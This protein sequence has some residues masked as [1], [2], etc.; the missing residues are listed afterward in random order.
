[1]ETAQL[2]VCWQRFREEMLRFMD[3]YDLIVSPVC[4][5]AAVPHGQTFAGDC[6]PGFSYTMTHNL[7]GWPV[8]VIRA[9]TTFGGLPIGVQI[10]ARPREEAA[11]LAAAGWLERSFGAW[12]SPPM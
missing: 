8:G 10:A 4:P 2:L 6:F 5:F 12:P 1:M 3:G 7:T 9:G 11:V